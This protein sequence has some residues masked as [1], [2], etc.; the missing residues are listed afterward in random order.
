M[1]ILS[2]KLSEQ[3]VI[4][5]VIVVTIVSIRGG[6]VRLGIEAPPNVSVDRKE[7]YEARRRQSGQK[8]QVTGKKAGPSDSETGSA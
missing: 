2:R 6:N 4:G 5:D 1:L 3:I 7:I 8:A